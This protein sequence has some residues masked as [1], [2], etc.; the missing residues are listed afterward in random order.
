MAKQSRPAGIVPILDRALRPLE[1]I[2]GV[3]SFLVM[4]LVTVLTFSM[5]AARYGLP[6]RM[7]WVVEVAGYAMLA[8][9]FLPASII[10]RDRG[11]I[12][13][14][15]LYSVLG[16]RAKVAC[17]LLVYVVSAAAI[18]ALGLFAAR[19]VLDNI[20]RNVVIIDVVDIPRW[21]LVLVIAVGCFLL[22]LRLIRDAINTAV[23]ARDRARSGPRPQDAA[24]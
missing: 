8:L 15:M 23:T 17:D 3:V 10:Q 18:S 11:H 5:V 1:G 24:G 9:A 13:L 21:I 2:T 19:T 12:R 20:R 6:F 14:D 7:V 16:P 4:T 22:G